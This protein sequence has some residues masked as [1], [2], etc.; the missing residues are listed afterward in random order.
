MHY[1]IYS[2]VH[3]IGFFSELAETGGFVESSESDQESNM[4]EWNNREVEEL[5]R[6]ISLRLQIGYDMRL[7][8]EFNKSHHEAELFI[9]NV[10]N[11]AQEYFEQIQRK[12]DFPLI[13]WR[14]QNEIERLV[15]VNI[16][17]DELCPLGNPRNVTKVAEIAKRRRHK[18]IPLIIFT[19]D[20]LSSSNRVAHTGCA[21]RSCICNQHAIGQGKNFGVV[22]V[23]YIDSTEE[24]RNQRIARV[25]AHELGHMVSGFINLN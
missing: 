20:Y 24:E 18:P 11:L 6:S 2:K 8:A 13:T 25:M 10:T 5:P 9:R 14:I 1:I 21:E 7:Y 16:T 23:T 19:E 22:D 15:D 12:I 3:T 17:S 4:G